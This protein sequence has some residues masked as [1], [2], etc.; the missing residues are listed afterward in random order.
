MRYLTMMFIL[1]AST[2]VA[3]TTKSLN[4][5]ELDI[6]D[7]SIDRAIEAAPNEVIDTTCTR[8]AD[9][10]TFVIVDGRKIRLL[11][12]NTPETVKSGV[13]PQPYGLE[14]STFTKNS[15]QGKL[16]HMEVYRK[17]KYGRTLAHVWYGKGRKQWLNA[18][19]V[20]NGYAV[21]EPATPARY[22]HKLFDLQ[23][24]AQRNK[25][26]IWTLDSQPRALMEV[27]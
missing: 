17:D 26:G 8:V 18:D 6:F 2:G 23:I 11:S 1:A 15:I 21:V 3:Q 9:G 5:Y 14:A 10:D 13:A 4:K 12:V 7:S 20:T 16:I 22:Y 27:E 24:E 25:R 19:L